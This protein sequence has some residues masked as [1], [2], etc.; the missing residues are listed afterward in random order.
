MKRGS[1]ENISFIEFKWSIIFTM[2]LCSLIIYS[3]ISLPQWILLIPIP[4]WFIF[5]V[6]R[7]VVIFVL[8]KRGVDE[9]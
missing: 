8:T 3:L 9:E 2:I 1:L 4:L 7:W 6:S 5:Q